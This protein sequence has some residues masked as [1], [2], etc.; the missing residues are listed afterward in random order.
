MHRCVFMRQLMLVMVEEG[1]RLWDDVN[2]CQKRF[3]RGSRKVLMG[4]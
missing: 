2:E 4:I 1:R 3:E